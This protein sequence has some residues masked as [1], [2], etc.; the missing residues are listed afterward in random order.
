MKNVKKILAVLL[1]AAFVIGSFTGSTLTVKALTY[2]DAATAIEIYGSFDDVVGVP[3]ETVHVK[4]PVRAVGGYILNPQISVDTADM[5]F[6]VKN[7]SYTSSGYSV[8]SPPTGI[9]N[10]ITSYIEFDIK[11]KETAPISRN[12]IKVKVEFVKV[13]E[14][15]TEET[16]TLDLS[17]A[18][19]AIDAEKE[20]AQLA[21]DNIV[22]DNG[23]IGNKT[24][25]SFHVTN[26]GEITSRTTYFS[27]DGFETAGIAPGYSKLSREVG[28]EGKLAAGESV[29]VTLPVTISKTA[30]AG[31]KTLTVNFTYKNAEGT[32]Y[33]EAV[34]IYVN[35]EENSMSPDIVIDSTKYPSELKSGDKFNLTTTLHN[36]GLTT[37]S[38]IKVAVE[39]LGTTSFLPN[40][41]TETVAGASLDSDKKS[42]VKIPL[43]VS[44]EAT[45][46]LKEVTLKITYKDEAGVSYTTTSK[47]YLE[48]VAADGVDT[49]GKPNII[50]SNVNQSPDQPS[51]G[52][53]VDIS[54]DLENKSKVDISDIKI[55]PT[56]LTAANFGPV[57]SEPYQYI[58]KL[59]GGKKT[60]ITYPLAVSEAI[61][62]GMSNLDI[63][64]TYKDAEGTP[65]TDTAT[66]YILD[67]QNSG[68]AS[69]P[70]LIISNF[71]TDSDELRA[72]S[73]FNFI[74]DIKN[75]H[76][77]ID[78]ENIK[79]TVAQADNIFS[80]TEGSNSFYISEIPAGET[81]ENQMSLRVKSDAV[82]KAYPIIIT[83]EYEYPGAEANPTTG[84]IGETVTS[85]IN[86]QAVENSRPVV[87]NVMV[88]SY[89]LPTV[90]QPTALT[91]EF[92]NMGKSTL[93]NVHATVEGD[94]TLT[95]GTMY[96]IGN[97]EAGMSEYAELEVMPAI[98]GQAKGSLI[99]TFED[100]N[101]EEVKVTQEFE[102]TVQGEIIPEY[103]EGDMGGGIGVIDT[104]V[105]EAILPVWL[106]VILQILI[107]VIAIPVTRKSILGLHRR[108]LRKQEEAE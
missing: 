21:I 102:A 105:K 7:I 76:S 80:V 31:N 40:F 83:I 42:D 82:T 1:T 33:T 11:V 5:P 84:E 59:E 22:L 14:S 92:Y 4:I 100:S 13:T 45:G 10:Y 50:V 67:I 103:N 71:S 63:Q 55:S 3:G 93:N 98:E 90:N 20:P 56:N 64:I 66:I 53:Q 74:F 6:S 91:F 19:L 35:I 27:I 24:E 28:N 87:N 43:I 85:T 61:P 39:G 62:E 38:D 32:S 88:G 51:A 73:T 2:Y 79:V 26:E 48:I 96:Y 29:K 25:L 97:V 8:D 49:T 107:L 108:K 72:G 104:P 16:V 23:V 65:F 77:N 94:Y 15:S 99:I 44:K 69:K 58:K 12:K 78:A 52:G 30:T 89:D 46:G 37:A 17:N 60:R 86:L 75:T 70:K 54:F 36:S 47:V 106:F 34:K 95:T 41:T 9:P 101:G 57:N 81:V 68:A 18:Y